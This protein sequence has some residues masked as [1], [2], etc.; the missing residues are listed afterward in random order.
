MTPQ[1]F[2]RTRWFRRTAIG[3]LAV[4]LLAW[5]FTVPWKLNFL[6][7]TIEQRVQAAT[8]R[9]LD[10]DGDVWWHWGWGRAWF[11]ANG[12]RFANPGWAG[13]PE[14]LSAEQVQAWI[15]LGP[16]LRARVD[17]PEVR[18]LKPDLWLETTQPGQRNWY[19]DTQQSDGGSA[20]RIGRVMLDQGRLHFVQKHLQTDVQVELQTVAVPVAEWQA[21]AAAGA[22]EPAGQAGRTTPAAPG[23]QPAPAPGAQEGQTPGRIRATAKGRW[24]GLALTARA[25]GDDVLKLADAADPY[26]LDAEAQVGGT[27]VSAAGTVTGLASPSAADLRVAVEGRSLGEWYRIIGV[28]LPDSPAYRTAGHLQLE[29]KVWRYEKFTSRVGSSDLGGNLVFEPAEVHGQRPLIKGE[30]VSQRLDLD[31][32]GPVI[33]LTPTPATSTPPPSGENAK[34]RTA[35]ATAPSRGRLLPQQKFSAE[36]WDTLDADVRFEG[37]AIRNVGAWPIDDLRFHVRLDDRNLRL[38]P[39]SLGVAGGAL[40]GSLAIDGRR[41]PMPTALKLDLRRLQLARLVPQVRETDKAALG[42]VNGRIALQGRGQSFAQILG[43][44]TGEVQLAMG[45]GTISN[46]ALEVAGLDVSQSLGLLVRGDRNVE[47]RCALVDTQVKGGALT[48]RAAVFDTADTIIQITGGANLADETLDLTIKPVAKDAS[49][50]TLRVPF[51]VKGT[52]A[53]PSFSPDKTR[54]VLRGGGAV[55]LGLINPLAAIIPLLEAGPGEDSDCGELM[56]RV[57][58]DGVPVADR[59]PAAARGGRAPAR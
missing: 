15:A 58:K 27:K 45:R 56:Q 16:L 54:L 46:L 50:L 25:E 53:D 59:Q 24:H 7:G 1:A 33:G 37:K 49:L 2:F 30:L 34:P 21:R 41:T 52:F 12:L 31:D 19:L 32:L 20:A 39:V 55:L 11:E 40:A 35:G 26:R 29:R 57:R 44:S 42:T 5:S 14:M 4:A 13:R 48:T 3:V 9:A 18:I 47:V 17:I 38:D 6:R 22:G 10:I 23:A 8:G 28:G 51:Y 43:T 36:K